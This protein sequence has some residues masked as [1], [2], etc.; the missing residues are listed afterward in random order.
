MQMTFRAYGRLCRVIE[1]PKGWAAQRAIRPDHKEDV[2]FHREVKYAESAQAAIA[3]L[4]E[5]L[6]EEAEFRKMSIVLDVLY[7]GH[8]LTLEELRPSSDWLNKRYCDRMRHIRRE[9]YTYD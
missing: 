9:L 2:W 6:R 1:T 8:N 4:M 7:K 5:M 3:F